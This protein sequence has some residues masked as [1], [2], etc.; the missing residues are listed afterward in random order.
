MFEWWAGVNF[1]LLFISFSCGRRL[2]IF[3]KFLMIVLYF[4]WL[5]FEL[6]AGV[7][8]LF[9]FISFSCGRRL[10]ILFV[11]LKSWLY[12][13]VIVYC[14]NCGLM[15]ISFF[16]YS[17]SCGRRLGILFNFVKRWLYSIVIDYFFRVV[18][19]CQLP[20]YFY[21]LFLWKMTRYLVLVCEK[22]TVLHCYLLLFELWAGV[23][24]LFI[25]FS[26]PVED[27]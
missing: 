27:D 26:S 11:F 13:I 10:G 8:F 4:Y 7:S 15:S 12:S 23:N 18:G 14:L 3:F 21:F 2:D 25:L 5:L 17:F 24:F 16:F 22:K 19:W 20:V 1:L 9:I 6:W